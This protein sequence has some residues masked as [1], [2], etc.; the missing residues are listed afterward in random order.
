MNHMLSWSRLPR[1]P[2]TWDAEYIVDHYQP[3]FEWILS[4]EGGKRKSEEGN[5]W[6]SGQAD[7]R[8]LVEKDGKGN[9]ELNAAGYL[10]FEAA[11]VHEPRP[12][13]VW[14]DSSNSSPAKKNNVSGK[15]HRRPRGWEEFVGKLCKIDCVSLVSY[16]STVYGGEEVRVVNGS[17]GILGVRFGPKDK[18]LPL[19]VETTAKDAAQAELVAAHIR[20]I[21]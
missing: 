21:K 18:Q 5:N 1:L 6:L 9:I 11:L 7:L 16:D 14:P 10:L 4:G 2:L 20:T 17:K 8:S 15:E 19:R 12:R 13:A 3:F